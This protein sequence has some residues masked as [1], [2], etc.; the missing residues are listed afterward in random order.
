MKSHMRFAFCP[1][2]CAQLDFAPHTMFFLQIFFLY[3]F[4]LICCEKEVKEK[5]SCS[6]KICTSIPSYE[7]SKTSPCIGDGLFLFFFK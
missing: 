7:W 6:C 4:Y 3:L 5:K 1:F 2:S